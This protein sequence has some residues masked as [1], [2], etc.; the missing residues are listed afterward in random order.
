MAVVAEH[1]IF[2]GLLPLLPSLTRAPSWVPGFL[3][4]KMLGTPTD[5]SVLDG[6]ENDG[7]TGAYLLE[8]RLTLLAISIVLEFALVNHGTCMCSSY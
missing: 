1:L 8:K 3:F 4:L 5:N 6:I 7:S 2:V